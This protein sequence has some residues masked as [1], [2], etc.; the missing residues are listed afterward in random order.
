[1]PPDPRYADLEG[2]DPRDR[3][4]WLATWTDFLRHVQFEHPG[5]LL[6]KNPLHTHR[7]PLIRRAFPEADFIHI[8]RD[9]HDM[10]PSCLHFWRRMYERHGLQRPT[11]AG[12]EDQ[13]FASVAGMDRRLADTWETI[14]ERRRYRT[15]YEDLV[16]DPLGVLRSIY[17]H[18]EWPG[19]AEAEPRWLAYLAEQRDYRP[20]EHPVDEALRARIDHELAGLLS[21]HGY[22]ARGPDPR[23]AC[24]T[25]PR[26]SA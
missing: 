20:N 5:R 1:M 26:S 13:V 3:N 25:P 6:L 18:F 14:P 9:P 11:C 22:P 24:E 21:R 2:L 19:L 23:A 17:R 10:V 4:R 8:A 15:R 12:L 16:A 7:V